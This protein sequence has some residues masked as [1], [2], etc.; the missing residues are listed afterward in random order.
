MVKGPSWRAF[1]TA[2]RCVWV[3]SALIDVWTI[4]VVVQV[5]WLTPDPTPELERSAIIAIVCAVSGSLI[6]IALS[7][8]WRSITESDRKD[9]P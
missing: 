1:K 7:Y 4:G 6:S 3:L 8:L 5:R 9:Y 2:A